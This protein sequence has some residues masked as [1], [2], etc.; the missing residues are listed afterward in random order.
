MLVFA[1]VQVKSYIHDYVTKRVCTA[2]VQPL[3]DNLVT[4]IVEVDKTHQSRTVVERRSTQAI[5]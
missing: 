2:K 3:L 4:R 1:H 5:A